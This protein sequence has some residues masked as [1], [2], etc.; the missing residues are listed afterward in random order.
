MAP[1]RWMALAA[2]ALVVSI[3]LVVLLIGGLVPHPRE[4]ALGATA[5]VLLGYVAVHAGIGLLFMG[6]RS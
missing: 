3:P 4:H 2:L 5:S 6:A 1:M